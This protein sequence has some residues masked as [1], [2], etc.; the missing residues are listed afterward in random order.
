MC[1]GRRFNSNT[2]AYFRHT[3]ADAVAET[4]SDKKVSKSIVSSIRFRRLSDREIEGYIKT[5]EPMSKAASYGMLDAAASFVQSVEG[6]WTNVAGLP[7]AA[8]V[9]ELKKFGVM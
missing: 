5:D 2:R 3:Y 7:L 1:C 6:E 8:L 9:K 4:D